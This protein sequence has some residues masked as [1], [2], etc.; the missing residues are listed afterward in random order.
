MWD[1]QKF[2]EENGIQ[3]AAEGVPSDTKKDIV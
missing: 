1:K 3:P 2:T